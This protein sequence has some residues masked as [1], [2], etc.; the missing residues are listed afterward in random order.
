MKASIDGYGNIVGQSWKVTISCRGVPFDLETNWS[1][2]CVISL[3]ED[4]LLLHSWKMNERIWYRE[5]KNAR[6]RRRSANNGGGQK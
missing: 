4:R 3:F 5:E 2:R 6:R 1:D